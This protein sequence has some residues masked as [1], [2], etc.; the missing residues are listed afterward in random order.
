MTDIETIFSSIKSGWLWV[1]SI[2][3]GPAFVLSIWKYLHSKFANV[4]MRAELEQQVQITQQ[5]CTAFNVL[6]TLIAS[7]P[8][9]KWGTIKF[10]YAD[11]KLPNGKNVRYSCNAYLKEEGMG[12]KNDSRNIP[13][14]LQSG[15]SRTITAAF[16]N[17][18]IKYWIC[19][20]Y[21]I[22]IVAKT[23][24]GHNA[25]IH[26]ISISL[27]NDNLS[28]LKAQPEAILPVSAWYL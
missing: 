14:P 3:G 2:F 28:I 25:K 12:Q 7:G 20:D 5:P 18:E 8:D 15:D 26:S 9:K 17:N 16:Q 19:G 6:F 11:V 13:I 24:D 22:T 21:E 10:E 23:A 27:N 1:S 4:K